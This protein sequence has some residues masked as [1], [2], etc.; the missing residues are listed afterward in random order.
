MPPSDA[1]HQGGVD[2][3]E[4]ELT[5]VEN[6]REEDAEAFEQ[7]LGDM[8][9]ALYDEVDIDVVVADQDDGAEGV[10][11]LV[12]ACDTCGEKL[13]VERD[14][15]F[16]S[17]GERHECWGDKARDVAMFDDSGVMRMDDRV[18]LE[19]RVADLDAERGSQ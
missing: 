10:F 16:I 4:V 1:G 12:V 2:R 8:F 17:Y 13:D 18:T 7:Y 3:L 9:I 5:I 19:L 15:Q 14:G 11:G 6:D